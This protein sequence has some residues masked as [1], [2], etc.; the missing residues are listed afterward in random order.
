MTSDILL[1]NAAQV[2]GPGP[3]LGNDGQEDDDGTASLANGRPVS[4]EAALN[5][6]GFNEAITSC[7][8]VLHKNPA[9]LWTCSRVSLIYRNLTPPFLPLFTLSLSPSLSISSPSPPPPHPTP[10]LSLFLPTDETVE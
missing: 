1:V 3:G 10:H 7:G 6:R 5:Q 2:P 9:P 8:F 4:A